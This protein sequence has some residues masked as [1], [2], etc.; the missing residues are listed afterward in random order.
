[1][2]CLLGLLAV[3]L[4]TGLD[5][6]VDFS[7]EQKPIA[8]V[9][10]LLQSMSQT[11]EE[12]Q[13]A[14]DDMKQKLD[15]W[16]KKNGEEKVTAAAA[17]Q[18]KVE[19]LTALV[20]EL[21]PKIEQLGTQIRSA[22]QELNKNKA[23]LETAAAIREEQLK[24]FKE[25]EA[26]LTASIDSVTKA[27]DAMNASFASSE[28]QSAYAS[29]VQRPDE[30]RRLAAGLQSTLATGRG[31]MTFSKLSSGERMTLDDF[32]KDPMTFLRGRSSFLQRSK[33]PSGSTIAGILQTL[34]DDFAEDLQK[35]LS[36]EKTNQKSYGELSAAKAQEVKLL[37]QQIIAKTE[38]KAEAQS[39]LEVSKEDIKATSKSRAADLEFQATVKAHCGTSDAKFRERSG[40]RQS[41][42]QAVSQALQVFQ[43]DEVRDLLRKSVSL[44][45]EGSSSDRAEAAG[46][47]LVQ[48]GRKLKAQSLVSLG[49]RK[50]D[51]FTKVKEAIQEMT[52]ALTKQKADEE[53][54]H[55]MCVDDLN[56]NQLS[57]EEKKGLQTS[58]ADKIQMLK[59]KIGACQKDVASLTA[60]VSEMETQIQLAG[61][62][63]QKENAQ[64]QTQATEQRQTQEVLKRAVQF[65]RK[66]YSTGVA[67]KS[68]LPQIS[69]HQV[70]DA[71]ARVE[72]RSQQPADSPE[73]FKDYEQS[74]GGASVIALIETIIGDAETLEAEAVQGEQDAQSSYE[75]F[76]AQTTASIKAKRAEV[77]GRMKEMADAK[78]DKAEAESSHDSTLQE[79]DELLEAKLALKKECDFFMLNFDVRQKALTDEIEALGQAALAGAK[80]SFM[81]VSVNSISRSAEQMARELC[82]PPAVLWVDLWNKDYEKGMSVHLED[83]SAGYGNAKSVL[84]GV[85]LEIAPRTK[86]A[87]VGKT[88]CGKSTTLL[89]ILRFLEP[90]CGRIRLGGNDTSKLGLRALRSI[91]G[92]VPQDPTVFEGTIRFNIDPFGEIPDARIW[93]AVQ[94]V[95]LMPYIRTLPD[96]IDS[97][98]DRDGSNIS[99]GQKQLLSL[100]RMVVRQPPILLLDECTSA[101]DPVTQEAAQ[102]TILKDFPRTTTIAVAHR[103]ETILDFDQI[104]VFEQG[105]VAALAP[106]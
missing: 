86:C 44:L 51:S 73:G 70:S 87:F 58:S 12:D 13:K 53:A 46:A 56:E 57:T 27:K 105:L 82:T 101:L 39:T 69:A 79:L 24:A 61:Q 90:R 63:R 99:F 48:Q 52:T 64:F 62:T 9:V 60:E 65:L 98:I 92:L 25:D 45:Q 66:F 28:M 89:C 5:S 55:E 74:A 59:A 17:A 16:C 91:V 43:G 18:D 76:L 6:V 49:L 80:E 84:H 67:Q 41:E 96:G 14:D 35:E 42:L 10:S 104:V 72:V 68:A 40:T 33:E 103:L 106:L 29:L 19:T 31:S 15:C 30:M 26:S 1:M 4:T 77:D 95:Q 88:G 81:I 36:D 11:L 32:M 8:K 34:V 50:L 23:T 71:N 2:L 22:T 83:I 75:D 3:R 93:E 94:S 47:Y 100:A 102:K 85:S 37:E 21:G 78:N 7:N 97:A 38:E 54:H 20:G